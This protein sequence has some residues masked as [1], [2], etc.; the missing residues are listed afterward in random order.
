VSFL[1]FHSE[2]T[3]RLVVGFKEAVWI[4]VSEVGQVTEQAI[5]FISRLLVT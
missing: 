2:E 1:V 4:G 3:A 5:L